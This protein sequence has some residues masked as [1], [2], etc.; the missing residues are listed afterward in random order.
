MSVAGDLGLYGNGSNHVTINGT[1]G[2][3]TVSGVINV[4][5]GSTVPVATVTG[6]RRWP[7]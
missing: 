2:V 1:T 3:L 5:A 6:L 4:I 7:R